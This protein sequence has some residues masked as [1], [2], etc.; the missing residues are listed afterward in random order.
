MDTQQIA[1]RMREM[2]MAGENES[3]YQQLYSPDAESIEMPGGANSE[4][5]H[6]RGLGE[7]AKKGEWWMNNFTI[8]SI[9][10]SE[11]LVADDWFA[12]RYTMDAEDKNNG[13]RHSM[14][15]LGV[16]QVRD[17]KVVREQFFYTVG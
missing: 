17:G 4:F 7:I 8:H 13:E 16:Y 2:N 6:C 12:L 9:E 10:V 5:E 3:I 1:E 15:E 11:P 14:S